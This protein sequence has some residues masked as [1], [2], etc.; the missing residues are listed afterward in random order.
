MNIE[1][2]E[3]GLKYQF[4]HR[5]KNNFN[6]KKMNLHKYNT[7]YSNFKNKLTINEIALNYKI[8]SELF[9]SEPL[10]MNSILYIC[11]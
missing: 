7:N 11:K 9:I 8:I 6:Q 10:T 5:K 2:L 3:K 4:I 1:I